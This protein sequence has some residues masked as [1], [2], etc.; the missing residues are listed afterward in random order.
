MNVWLYWLG[1]SVVWKQAKHKFIIFACYKVTQLKQL[2]YVFTKL[3]TFGIGAI[4][5]MLSD[6]FTYSVSDYI[7][8]KFSFV[9]LPV[10]WVVFLQKFSMKRVLPKGASGPLPIP[11]IVSAIEEFETRLSTN[12]SFKNVWCEVINE[13]IVRYCFCRLVSDPEIHWTTVLKWNDN[14]GNWQLL[15]HSWLPLAG[16]FHYLI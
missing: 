5:W 1:G 16:A 2:R 13:I 12:D 6:H 11:K 10:I 9:Q 4:S 14:D 3:A 8:T 7:F 15:L